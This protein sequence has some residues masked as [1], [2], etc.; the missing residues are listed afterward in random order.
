MG[1]SVNAATA[2]LISRVKV[3]TLAVISAIITMM[4]PPLM[5]TIEIGQNYWYSPFWAL[6]LSPVNPD[7]MSTV[8]HSLGIYELLTI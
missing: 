5:A 8:P 2:Y 7:G 3:R 6:F 1:I 4:A